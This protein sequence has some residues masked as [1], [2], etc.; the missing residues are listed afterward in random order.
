[1]TRNSALYSPD[2]EQMKDVNV[3]QSLILHVDSLAGTYY[4]TDA[5]DQSSPVRYAE[6]DVTV[7]D[8][9]VPPQKFWHW[10]DL[11]G[12]SQY[13]AGG[14]RQANLFKQAA[15]KHGFEFSPGKKMLDFGC[16]GGRVT[17]W[18]ADEAANGVDV[19]GCDIDAAAIEWCQKNLMPTFNFF[20]NTTSPHLPVKDSYFD[21]IFAGSVFTHIKDMSTAWAMELS[22]C[23]SDDGVAVY[24]A[25]TEL[26]LETLYKVAEE[27][28]AGNKKVPKFIKDNNITDA[29]LKER[30]FITIQ[31]SPWWLAAIYHSE[32]FK[33]RLSMCYDV[34][35]ILPNLKG[36]QT[37]FVLRNKK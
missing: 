9:P 25:T 5:D 27:D 11:G 13:L 19:W 14:K 7:N 28:V 36:Y 16:S 15:M 10:Y 12:E 20:A 33:R 31:S 34:V 24:T 26:S 29:Y 1:M 30:G 18:F 37:G 17:R 2:G 23:L 22:R 32:F 3:L 6:G 21:F 8:L 4:P 35:E